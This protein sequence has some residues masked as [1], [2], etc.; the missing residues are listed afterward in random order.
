MEDQLYNDS[1]ADGDLDISQSNMTDFHKDFSFRD[2]VNVTGYTIMSAGKQSKVE[3]IVRKLI[4]RYFRYIRTCL[5]LTDELSITHLAR[6][7]KIRKFSDF[8]NS[9]QTIFYFFVFLFKRQKKTFIT[10][11]KDVYL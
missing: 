10:L 1:F 7:T 8:F 2:G 4:M 6:T 11:N 3:L 9:A 5:I